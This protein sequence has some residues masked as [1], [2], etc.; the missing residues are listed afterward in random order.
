MTSCTRVA[1]RKS[2]KRGYGLPVF[3]SLNNSLDYIL[4]TNW[5]NSLYNSPHNSL[6]NSLHN[7]LHNCLLNSLHNTLYVNQHSLQIFLKH[8]LIPVCVGQSFPWV[9]LMFLSLLP[10]NNCSTIE[11]AL[12]LVDF[13]V[14]LQITPENFIL[15]NNFGL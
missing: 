10:H 9:C 14:P 8:H 3:T 2:R 12:K 15:A 7:S 6:Q 5:H 1:S 11:T 4:H 13:I